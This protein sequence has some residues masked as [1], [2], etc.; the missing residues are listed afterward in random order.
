MVLQRTCSLSSA[1]ALIKPHLSKSRQNTVFVKA[2]CCELGQSGISRLHDVCRRTRSLLMLSGPTSLPRSKTT[3]TL[4]AVF[5]GQQSAASVL[6]RSEA[7]CIFQDISGDALLVASF[8]DRRSPA[9]CSSKPS[10]CSPKAVEIRIGSKKMAAASKR[11]SPRGAF[12]RQGAL[13]SSRGGGNKKD[14]RA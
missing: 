12:A 1:L 2:T 9:G 3:S 4:R 11:A 6:P 10:V 13:A 7:G 5:A 14:Q 8:R